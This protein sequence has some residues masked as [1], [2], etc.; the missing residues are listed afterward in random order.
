MSPSERDHSAE[1]STARTVFEGYL[2]ALDRGLDGGPDGEPDGEPDGGPDGGSADGS[3]DFEVLVS[4]HPELA[5]ELRALRREWQ[6]H[7]DRLDV[8]MPG[9]LP[10]TVDEERELA[11]R[12][13][14][15]TEPGQ[16]LDD[17]RLERR[18]GKGAMGDVWEA[19]QLSLRRRVA[20][21]VLKPGRSSGSD[22]RSLL[23]EAH[24]AGR[25][26]HDGIVSV[27]AA[28]VAEGV[29]WIAQQLVGEGRT[30][31]DV[32][33]ERTPGDHSEA[34][35]RRLAAL[36]AEIADAV[37]AAHEVGVLHR[38]LK[39]RNILIGRD[40]RPRVGDFGL[41]HVAEDG[42]RA[43]RPGLLG[44][45][46]YMSPEQSGGDEVAIDRRSDVFSLGAVLYEALARRQAFPGD[47]AEQIIAAIR[48]ETPPDP[49]ALRPSVPRDLALI[50]AKALE[51]ERRRRYQT[52]AELRDDLRRYLDH[53]PIRARPVGALALARKWS[54]RHPAQAVA[55]LLGGAALLAVTLLLVREFD[56][57]RDAEEQR[58][59]A[60][61]AK[62]EAVEA[63]AL[64][65][66]RAEALRRE[67]YLASVRAAAMDL[68]R[69]HHAEAR[70][71][72]LGC[73]EASRGW[74]WRHFLL[75]ADTSLG[76]L[77]GHTDAVL[78]VASS[79]DGARVVTGSRDGTARVW[80]RAAARSLRVLGGHASPVTAVALSAD[81]ARV[82]SGTQDGVLRVWDGLTGE[83][84]TTLARRASGV[85]SLALS[86]D[87]ARLAAGLADGRAW[88]WDLGAS[89]SPAA[90]PVVVSGVVS[91]DMDA[92]GTRL[93]TGTRYGTVDVWYLADLSP[94]GRLSD[95]ARGEAVVALNGQATRALAGSAD[96]T[97]R[98]WD[99]DESGLDAGRELLG[100]EAHAARVSAVALSS[101]GARGLSFSDETDTLLLWDLERG[102][103][104]SAL[105]GLDG[106]VTSLALSADGAWAMAGGDDGTLRLWDGSTAGAVTPL[107]GQAA[108]AVGLLSASA[109]GEVV[110]AATAAEGRVQLWS[111]LDGRSLGSAAV[112]P[113]SVSDVAVSADGRRLA[114]A[115]PDGGILIWDL[116]PG[117]DGPALGAAPRRLREGAEDV[118]TLA[119]TTGGRR[120]VSG[121]RDALVRLWDTD[122]GEVVEVFEGHGDAVTAV[123]VAADGGRIASLAWDGLLMVWEP[124][125]GEVLRVDTG[126]NY[127][128]GALAFD[129]TGRR[130][131]WGM[132][133]SPAIE[134]LDV[135]SGERLA[136]LSGSGRG[137][138]SLG[139]LDD[140]RRLVAGF[141]GSD[142]LWAWNVDSGE[143]VAVLPAGGGS[144]WS[145]ASFGDGGRVV[146]GD[147]SGAVRV[148]ETDGAAA[149]RLWRGQH[150]SR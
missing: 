31:A 73:D 72:L 86:A 126:R 10:E 130:L 4:R 37:H 98:L 52:M 84:Q 29:P 94:V 134:V 132:I 93:I 103:L 106:R 89:A 20:L 104:L 114:A 100:L 146:T 49:R 14:P 2:E 67:S 148:W 34:A 80:D 117:A 128:D 95:F 53:Q 142:A 119:F 57:R 101:D 21:K 30:L 58:E 8:L 66:Q 83:V 139:L 136:Q 149:L 109:G 135:G 6:S 115:A 56:L 40:G 121:S 24:A 91:V 18:L 13:A 111:G 74:E 116:D 39:P 9:P 75:R 15:P 48:D 120:L 102:R 27:Y 79:A 32:L 65:E 50:A 43:A 87:G 88:V 71:R 68:E 125:R 138:T 124:G 76:V 60:D 22:A 17:F 137:V 81:G 28:G 62:A 35:Y 51:K 127:E 78:A 113:V 107:A 36:F 118:S 108:G 23:N 147:Q 70:R 141:A 144:L 69:G 7:E 97:L 105:T 42:G 54:R 59:Q 44:T 122:I 61:Q 129:A 38:D 110:A 133:R 90:Q 112:H 5:D 3:T 25:V 64:A 46:A 26:D 150:A 92:A 11:T 99:V 41:A 45:Y 131:A 47:T 1:P 77:R 33:E 145:L 96:G 19:E 123:A 143:L 12:P 55:L 85:T 140:G 82:V 63:L 16:V